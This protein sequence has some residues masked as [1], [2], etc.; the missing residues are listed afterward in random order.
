MYSGVSGDQIACEPESDAGLGA[1]LG[2]GG[3]GLLANGLYAQFH[4]IS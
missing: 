1:A 4:C 2:A 3:R